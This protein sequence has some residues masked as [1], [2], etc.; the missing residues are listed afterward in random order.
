MQ[1]WTTVAGTNAEYLDENRRN[2]G[3]RDMYKYSIIQTRSQSKFYLIICVPKPQTAKMLQ[4]KY[5]KYFWI[6]V[7]QIHFKVN[8]FATCEVKSQ[9]KTANLPKELMCACWQRYVAL[10]ISFSSSLSA[11]LLLP[12][13]PCVKEISEDISCVCEGERQ[14]ER[15]LLVQ[16]YADV[17][18]AV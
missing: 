8:L 7:V 13:S 11:M 18:K 15:D 12:M 9:V 10:L 17:L 14:R 16:V 2:A 3:T 5:L 1:T 6:C 4:R